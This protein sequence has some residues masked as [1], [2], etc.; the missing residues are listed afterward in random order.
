[1]KVIF[2]DT[3]ISSTELLQILPE[4][5]DIYGA[6]KR[7]DLISLINNQKILEVIIIDGVF[8]QQS[9]ITHKEILYALYKG[10]KIIG[11]SSMGALRASELYE[12]GMIGYGEIFELYKTGQIDADDEVAVSSIKKNNNCYVSIPLINIRKTVD[13]YQLSKEIFFKAKEI[14]YAERSWD[15]LKKVLKKDEYQSLSEKY[16]DL[17]KQDII[18]YFKGNLN[19]K[20]CHT[21]FK[22]FP[23]IYL[24]H[25]ISKI[26]NGSKISLIKN[27]ILDYSL[28]YKKSNSSHFYLPDICSFL[29]LEVEKYKIVEHLLDPYSE[30][31]FKQ[32]FIMK[33]KKE[34][35]N[36]L[37]I[38]N[39]TQLKKY[40]ENRNIGNQSLN[41]IFDCLY[42]LYF[43]CLSNK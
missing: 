6:I 39:A 24:Q 12:F 34:I 38:T 43:I 25:E 35:I 18:A 2:A 20:I 15:R 4:K 28:S 41:K 23:S 22:Y 26:I 16:I 30:I 19:L 31:E 14:F 3:T 11:L 10:V 42:K 7:G 36:E 13:K 29:D 1:M 33:F 27:Y 8:G 32:N 17:K 21:N 5:Y 40:L 37:G 9:S